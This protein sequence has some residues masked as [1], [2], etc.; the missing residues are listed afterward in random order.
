MK[1]LRTLALTLCC[2]LML[3]GAE[4]YRILCVGDSITAMGGWPEQLEQDL[5]QA[6]LA[7]TLQRIAKGGITP[8]GARTLITAAQ[9]RLMET[10][11]GLALVML[12]TN[13]Y[14]IEDLALVVDDLQQLGWPVVV[15][16]PP[17]RQNRKPGWGPAHANFAFGNQITAR[18]PA[19]GKALKPVQHYDLRHLLRAAE[20][21]ENQDIIADKYAADPTHPT[22]AARQLLGAAIA[23]QLLAFTERAK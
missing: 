22:K 21:P 18:W 19:W 20:S 2:L 23:K 13:A 3:R 6:G 16:C 12:G 7:L 4:P 17:P 5:K 9:P 10:E 8:G 14:R 15:L 11:E 1:I